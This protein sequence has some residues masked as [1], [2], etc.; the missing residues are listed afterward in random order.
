MDEASVIALWQECEL[1]RPWNDPKEDI[2]RKLITQPELFLVGV[3]GCTVVANAMIGFDG[4]R[5]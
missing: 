1:T 4:N 3:E 5:G 2:N